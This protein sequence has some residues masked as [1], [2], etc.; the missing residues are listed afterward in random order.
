MSLLASQKSKPRGPLDHPPTVTVIV[1]TKNNANTVR[2]CV[3]SILNL[4]Y[5][6]DKLRVLVVDASSNESTRNALDGLPVEI[7]SYNGNAP[8]AYN[9]A[10]GTVR[11]DLVAFI[12]GDAR[13]DP[14]WLAEITKNLDEQGVAGAAGAMRTW[15][16]QKIIPRCIGYELESRY[17]NPKRVVRASTTNLVLKRTAIEEA[18]G[19]D[20]SLDTG[21]DADIGFRIV[22]LG[23][24]I[25][26]EP[27][28]VVYHFHRPAL[29]SYWRQQY[30]YAKND[31][32]LYS[33]NAS[34]LLA[35]NVTR[36]WMIVQPIL[37][38][39]FVISSI[40]LLTLYV[41]A[42][43][44]YRITTETMAAIWV[45][46]GLL[47]TGSYAFTS[48]RLALSAR[49]PRAWP[50]L[51]CILVTRAVAWT[52]GGMVGLTQDILLHTR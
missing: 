10:L 37:V 11:S 21:Y 22:G 20:E 47:L 38:F 28:A 6:K 25:I 24:R 49:E 1:T 12:D 34:L 9:F 7:V 52:L 33:K 39:S 29:R 45:G 17:N 26:F 13:V 40:T 14:F 15:N 16:K 44:S 23:Y 2:E 46:I 43:A 32:K 36:K 27:E 50:I 41:T 48:V 51:F 5:P 8:A 18:G 3:A 19:F 31:A 30:V 42:S 4:D 35:D